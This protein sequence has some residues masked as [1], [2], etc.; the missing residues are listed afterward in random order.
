MA[1]I[2]TWL[3]PGL[4]PPETF[5]GGAAAVI[6]LLRA[7]TTIA[8][9]LH[10]GAASVVP[11]ATPEDAR[12]ARDRDRPRRPLLGGERRGVRIPGFDL[13]NS[14][15][16]YTPARV[17]GADIYFTTTNGTAAFLHASRA[18]H[19]YAACL[20]NLT[21]V[22]GVLAR[23]LE[24]GELVHLVCAGTGGEVALEDAAC[25]GAIVE[26]LAARAPGVDLDDAGRLALAAWERARGDLRAFLSQGRG[27]RNLLALGLGADIDACAEIDA[28]ARVPAWDGNALRALPPGGEFW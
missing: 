28:H 6:D 23:C 24:R 11:C 14:P 2:R 27:G 12:A 20:N 18:T 21:G 8:R 25:A 4:A 1:R 15:G 26:T 7:T 5:A 10:A 22:A 13:S 19:R 9:A 16:E 3:H 17:A